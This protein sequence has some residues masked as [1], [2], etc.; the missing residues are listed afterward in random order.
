MK[1][2]KGDCKTSFLPGTRVLDIGESFV[3]DLTAKTQ[4]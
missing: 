4:I 3:I 1:K 2:K